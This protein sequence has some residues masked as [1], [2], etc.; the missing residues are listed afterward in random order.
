MGNINSSF[1][2][3]Y[4]VYEHYI[5][6][7]LFYIGK[8]TGDRASNFT[9]RSEL[10]LNKVAKR[11]AEVEIK[12]IA[13]FNYDSHAEAFEKLH[14]Q[15]TVESE[16]GHG[17]VNRTY[18]KLN[19]SFVIKKNDKY[20]QFNYESKCKGIDFIGHIYQLENILG[21]HTEETTK[22]NYKGVAYTRTADDMKAMESV[23]VKAGY[24]PLVI[25][26]IKRDYKMFNSE[27]LQL[28]DEV[29]R[30]KKI[31]KPY[32]FLIFN[33][34][35][36]DRISLEDDDIEL[37]ILNTTDKKISYS[38]R[39]FVGKSVLKLIKKGKQH[40]CKPLYQNIEVPAEYL[41]KPL[42]FKDKTSL[43]IRLNVI[44]QDGK[45]SKWPSIRK[46]LE[47][48]GYKINDR[49]IAIDGKRT[50]TTTITIPDLK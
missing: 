39:K 28:V 24:N 48:L 17:L 37:I 15:N 33:G 18:N 16:L 23:L 40:D 42:T 43:Y 25:Y 6:N 50:R 20:S 41:D 2:G 10:W 8:G 38:V 3:T 26:S 31:P 29:I 1:L 27:H 45:V 5:N 19:P 36:L 46:L 44:D 13:K 21:I 12:I 32:D 11:E 34:S 9:C 7:E 47:S 30:T 35:L 4:Y 49:T 22:L 14:I